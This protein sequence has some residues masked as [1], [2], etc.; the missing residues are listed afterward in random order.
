MIHSRKRGRRG[1]SGKDL[2]LLRSNANWG[3]LGPDRSTTA[4]TEEGGRRVTGDRQG[5]QKKQEL[6]VQ[7]NETASKGVVVRRRVRRKTQHRGRVASPDVEGEGE[8]GV[9]TKFSWPGGWAGS[10]PSGRA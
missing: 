10:E 7:L 4:S 3:V 8:L 5:I 6:G 9:G 1:I 2:E